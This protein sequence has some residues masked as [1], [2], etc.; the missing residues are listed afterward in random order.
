MYVGQGAGL[1]VED[2]DLAAVHHRP[3]AE[4][5]KLVR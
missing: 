3:D 4:A 2:A 1:E 5:R